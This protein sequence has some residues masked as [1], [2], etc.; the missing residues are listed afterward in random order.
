M[1]KE[2]DGEQGRKGEKKGERKRERKR[3]GRRERE[4]EME[5]DSVKQRQSNETVRCTVVFIVQL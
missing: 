3:E 5:G 1:R 4:R 2:G